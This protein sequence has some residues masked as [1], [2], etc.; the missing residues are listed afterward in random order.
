MLIF[1]W[2]CSSGSGSVRVSLQNMK[3]MAKAYFATEVQ[4]ASGTGPVKT[5][6]VPVPLA[7]ESG[8]LLAKTGN[9]RCWKFGVS[10][11][12]SRSCQ[13][14]QLGTLSGERFPALTICKALWF[15]SL[16]TSGGTKHRPKNTVVL[17]ITVPA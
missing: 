17:I 5:R 2:L 13:L 8:D 3:E 1:G 11:S 15:G 4:K 12:K 6:T 7:L 9:L 16:H 10:P 14:R